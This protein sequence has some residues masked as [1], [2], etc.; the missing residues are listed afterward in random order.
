[1]TIYDPQGGNGI[2]QDDSIDLCVRVGFKKEV[3]GEEVVISFRDT[4]I[5][6]IVDL[7]A[8]FDTFTVPII[9]VEA[10]T[11]ETDIECSI[12]IIAYLCGTKDEVPSGDAYGLG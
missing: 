10:T 1:M 3:K 9:G 2:T 12:D 6:G 4:K 11:F 5:R 7:T 8:E